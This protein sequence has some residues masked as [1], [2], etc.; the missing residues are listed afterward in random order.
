MMAE[1]LL[2]GVC[3]GSNLN[4]NACHNSQD[5]FLA[6]NPD[7]MMTEKT[8]EKRLDRLFIQPLPNELKFTGAAAGILYKKELKFG[9]CDGIYLDFKDQGRG[10]IGYE[11]K[12]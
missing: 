7:I 12:F 3:L 10:Y 1:F 11:Y 2:I 4:D 6:L 9:V 8:V 5:K